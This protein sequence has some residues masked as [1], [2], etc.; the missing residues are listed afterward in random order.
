LLERKA[1]LQELLS[2]AA[3]GLR[4]CE[5]FVEPG[6]QVLA[7]ACQIGAEGLVSKRADAPYAPGNRGMWVKTKCLKR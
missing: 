7:A 5:H 1:K 3:A 6:P 2:R 4:Y